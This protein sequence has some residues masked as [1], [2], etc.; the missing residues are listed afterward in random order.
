[1]TYL[2]NVENAAAPGPVVQDNFEELELRNTF[3]RQAS[4]VAGVPTGSYGPPAGSAITGQLWTDA[5][6]NQWLCVTGGGTP[7]WRRISAWPL[8]LNVGGTDVNWDF[9]GVFTKS[10]GSGTTILSFSNAR[11]G[12]AIRL[13]ITRS[14]S[15]T[16]Q[17]TATIQWLTTAYNQTHGV[18][19]DVLDFFQEDGVIYGRQRTGA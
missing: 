17:L 10:I 18:S 7:A 14:T 13:I 19:K 6:R 4:K 11:D 15:A 2:Q 9:A 1:M 5:G 8:P 12:S 16:L 3:E